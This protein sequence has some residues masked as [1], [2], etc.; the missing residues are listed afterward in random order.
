MEYGKR[1]AMIPVAGEQC[2]VCGADARDGRSF[3]HLYPEGRQVTLCGPDCAEKYLR[4]GTGNNGFEGSG[5]YLQELAGQRSWAL[6]R[7]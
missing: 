3:C 2:E 1:M 4:R 5:D 7:S 6:W